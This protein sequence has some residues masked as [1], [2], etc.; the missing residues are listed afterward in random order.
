[1]EKKMQKNS[2]SLFI[3]II[4][5]IDFYNSNKKIKK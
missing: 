5:L 3:I 1:M 2:K 4:I